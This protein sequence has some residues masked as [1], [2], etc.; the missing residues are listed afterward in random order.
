MHWGVQELYRKVLKD[1]I[2]NKVEL[3]QVT[4]EITI[5]LVF[6][7][8]RNFQ[9]AKYAIKQ[10]SDAMYLRLIWVV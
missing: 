9:A 8:A 6:R 4:G 1:K 10:H 3:G 2:K 7:I 5:L